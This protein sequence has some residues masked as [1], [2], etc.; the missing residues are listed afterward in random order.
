MA[1]SIDRFN[2]E[3][4]GDKTGLVPSKLSSSI[5][6]GFDPLVGSRESYAGA[7]RQV[8]REARTSA[9]APKPPKPPRGTGLQTIHF[10]RTF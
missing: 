1:F 4:A 7:A 9:V 8:R 2:T 6:S 3:Y 5:G 10:K